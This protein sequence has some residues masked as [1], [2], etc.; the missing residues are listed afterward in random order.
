MIWPLAW[1]LPYDSGTAVKKKKK[2][3]IY[4][5]EINKLIQKYGIILKFKINW[6]KILNKSWWG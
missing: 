5:Y 1:E 6:E 3:Q 2:K 4:K